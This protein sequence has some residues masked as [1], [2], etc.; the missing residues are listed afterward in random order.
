MRDRLKQA[1]IES[2]VQKIATSGGERI[3]VRVGSYS[4]RQEA[5]KVKARLAMLGLGGTVM[6]LPG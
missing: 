5:D 6:P 3:R 1:G 4:S 2:Y